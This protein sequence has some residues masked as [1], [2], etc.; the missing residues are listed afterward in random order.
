[1]RILFV[2]PLP[3]PVTG[4]AMACEAL[5]SEL[6]KKHAVEILN[7]NKGTLKQGISSFVRVVEV[8]KLL[9]KIRRKSSNADII[10][11]TLSQSITGNIKDLL[12]Y[13]VCFK[14][15]DKMIIHLHGGGI[16]K[17]IFDMHPFLRIVNKFFLRRVGGVI[18]LSKSLVSVF[19]KM[20]LPEKIHIVSNFVEDSIFL[21]KNDIQIKFAGFS[22]LRILFLS[23]LIPRKGFEELAA[24]YNLLDSSLKRKVQIDFAG[25]FE[26]ESQKRMFL[27]KIKKTQGLCYHGVVLGREK[28][29]LFAKAHIFCL[30]T[31]YYYE[32]QPI[33]ILEAY[34]AGCAVITTDHGGIADIFES[35]KM[36]FYVEKKSAKSIADT[37]E[38]ILSEP[39]QLEQLG[40]H[41]NTLAKK[42]YTKSKHLSLLL[43]IMVTVH[44]V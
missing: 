11:L 25:D 23:N 18:V 14:K 33:S 29:Q 39:K 37:I 43:N 9:I 30:P 17:L 5:L 3:P 16:R 12:T 7:F 6:R 2:A 32:G 4:Q 38:N 19:D 42:L 24:A 35:G 27:N 28:K 21:T 1:M 40:I 41:N 8:L 44:R 22:P 31:Y 34:A 13:F 20:V 10:Y 15:L 26:S 36:G